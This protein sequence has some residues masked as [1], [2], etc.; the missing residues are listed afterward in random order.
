MLRTKLRGQAQMG[1]VE[2]CAEIS[3]T[4]QRAPSLIVEHIF[5]FVKGKM[6]GRGETLGEVRHAAV[7]HLLLQV[8]A[9]LVRAWWESRARTRGWERRPYWTGA[10]AAVDTPD[11]GR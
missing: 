5:N 1:S 10:G 2:P 7:P 8:S 9:L 3:V 6:G 4:V 11:L